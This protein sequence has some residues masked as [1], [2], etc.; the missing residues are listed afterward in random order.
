M[1]R[2]GSFRNR[3]DRVEDPCVI[4]GND[5]NQNRQNQS[6]QGRKVEGHRINPG[7]ADHHRIGDEI[8]RDPGKNRGSE[9]PFV[10]CSH[11]VFVLSETNEKDRDHRCHDRNR[12]QNQWEFSRNRMVRK[13]QA[14]QQHCGN[15]GHGIGFK[16]IR[17]H[18]STVTDIIPDVVCNHRGIPRVILGNSGFDFTDEISSHI[19]TFGEDS[20]SKPCED[21]DQTSAET[22][23]YQ[24]DDIVGEVVKARDCR[25]S[26]SG[27]HHPGDR[28]AFE[29]QGKSC[30]KS[31]SCSF[32]GSD[33]GQYR[34]PHSN[35]P[36][37]EGCYCSNK[38]TNTGFQIDAQPDDD[39]N[40]DS[41]HGHGD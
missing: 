17:G 20:S 37:N 40:H 4:L 39:E 38:K 7:N 35:V 30:G 32:S 25:Q 16:E 8:E 9:H 11:D 21:R 14:S 28:P 5:H 15:R 34:N 6:N 1:S 10:E 19:G 36:R 29:C 12:T 31:L 3:F 23:R 27:D 18:A 13:D 41:R 33:I 24:C 22:K 26:Q 2:L